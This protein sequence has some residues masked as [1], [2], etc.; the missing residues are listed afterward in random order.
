MSWAFRVVS[1]HACLHVNDR[2]RDTDDRDSSRTSSPNQCTN[3]TV[4]S[5]NGRSSCKSYR[6]GPEKDVQNAMEPRPPLGPGLATL[7]LDVS[8]EPCSDV[9]DHTR[10]TDDPLTAR[11]MEKLVKGCVVVEVW[12]AWVYGLWQYR[13]SWVADHLCVSAA[14]AVQRRL[15]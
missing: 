2:K 12:T 10:N 13:R 6:T 7:P 5:S 1:S 11:H 3:T 9:S 14:A 15:R 4:T 8:D